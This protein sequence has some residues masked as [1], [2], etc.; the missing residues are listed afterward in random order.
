MIRELYELFLLIRKETGMQAKR[1]LASGNG[2]RK[3]PILQKICKEMFLADLKLSPF[4]E[5][6]ACGAAIA[7]R[8]A[9]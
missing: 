8:I 7:A 3:N 1:I 9:P 6:A 2:F 4:L 5:E